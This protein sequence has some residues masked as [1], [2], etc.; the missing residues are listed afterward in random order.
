MSLQVTFW[1]LREIVAAYLGYPKP[2]EEDASPSNWSAKQL[3]DVDESIKSGYR[4][5]LWPPAIG[6]SKIPH[7]WSFLR[8][9][10]ILSL[11]GAVSAYQFDDSVANL[12]NFG[13][14]I[15]N[16]TLQSS[17]QP[18]ALRLS[19]LSQPQ[20]DAISASGETG[21]PRF[22][23]LR[24]EAGSGVDVYS[25]IVHPTPDASYTA[26]LE[27]LRAPEELSATNITP[28]G[29]PQHS[30]TI[31]QACLAVAES[32]KDD[33]ASLHQQLWI[34]R[35]T[36]SIEIDKRTEHREGQPYPVA[37]E[38]TTLDLAYEDYM[39]QIGQMMG[40]GN[41]RSSWSF[42]QAQLARTILDRGYRMV[43]APELSG[44]DP[45][46]WSW[47]KS[48][49][50]LNL[51]IGQGVYRLPDDFNTILSDFTY[52]NPDIEAAI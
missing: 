41:D 27:F 43:M 19:I 42:D 32:R 25:I 34:Q 30:E 24:R 2:D 11:S 15:T 17:T 51:V 31:V 33:S 38:S 18:E 9:R 45:Y 7:D 52:V 20:M 3:S 28:F 16:A 23:S 49:A 48:I 4:N 1:S 13:G 39:I 12:D 40:W 35:L 29:G 50:R 36:A 47:M 14:V 8:G 6:D 46:C 21:T 5:F 22:L 37:N 44:L 26:T 10:A